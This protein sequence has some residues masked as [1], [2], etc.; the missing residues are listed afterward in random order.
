MHFP[1]FGA[2][3]GTNLPAH[4]WTRAVSPGPAD[5]RR[6][7]TRKAQDGRP[8]ES[9]SFDLPG[10]VSLTGYSVVQ[11]HTRHI[12]GKLW[13]APKGAHYAEYVPSM[14]RAWRFTMHGWMHLS[15]A[16]RIAPPLRERKRHS[17]PLLNDPIGI[18]IRAL[19]SSR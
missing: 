16:H 4:S 17:S 12:L 8:G 6:I 11:P 2:A 10:M 18:M 3:D 9:G 13:R 1:R 14:C 5:H 7:G 15:T 19:T